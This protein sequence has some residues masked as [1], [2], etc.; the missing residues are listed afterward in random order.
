MLSSAEIEREF[1][2]EIQAK[3][4]TALGVHHK[5][6]KNGYTGVVR[7]P[8]QLLRG[9]EK[10]D[11]TKPG[12]VHSFNMYSTMMKLEELQRYDQD[13]QKE[14][15][16]KW[17]EIHKVKE[18]QKTLGIDSN[19][20][21]NLLYNLGILEK[22]ASFKASKGESNK[23]VKH[24]ATAE[25]IIKYQDLK[26]MPKEK[27][28]EILDD[29][30]KRYNLPSVAEIWGRDVKSIY[31][32]RYTL[33]KGLEK[34]KKTN[35]EEKV[36]EHKQQTLNTEIEPKQE[37]ILEENELLAFE[38]SK[39]KAPN[40]NELEELRLIVEQQAQLLQSLIESQKAAESVA[41]AVELVQESTPAFTMNFEKQTEGFILH[42]DLKRFITVLEKNPDT[43]N[44]KIEITRIEE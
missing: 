40:E 41:A 13:R 24:I 25:D 26:L 19:A 42:Q 44:V 21:Y 6:G 12:E 8:H 14:I 1:R 27:Q 28:L 39:E 43:F 4:R 3:K 32:L 23:K 5:T 2:Y 22:P 35:V 37:E 36:D 7:F 38:E 34:S 11:Y 31:S 20:Y 30:N 16:E 15:V 33:R 29:Y 17:R 9:K 10:R 18:I